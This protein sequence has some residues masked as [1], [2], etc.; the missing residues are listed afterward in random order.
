M[1][2]Y[3]CVH[4]LWTDNNMTGIDWGHY[5]VSHKSHFT[6]F[7][8]PITLPES[9]FQ[10]DLIT[11]LVFEVEWEL[12]AHWC[13]PHIIIFPLCPVKSI[14]FHSYFCHFPIFI[15]IHRLWRLL[16]LIQIVP[17]HYWHLGSCQCSPWAHILVYL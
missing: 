15:Y 4:L 16:H 5:F 10:A 14:S 9:K 13:S 11:D 12:N 2:L 7:L 8:S 6:P 17:L 1:H 3:L